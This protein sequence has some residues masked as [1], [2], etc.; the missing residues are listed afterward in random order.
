V[1]NS[2]IAVG[3]TGEAKETTKTYLSIVKVIGL[4][5]KLTYYNT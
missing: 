4:P 1:H 3:D 5:V 2:S